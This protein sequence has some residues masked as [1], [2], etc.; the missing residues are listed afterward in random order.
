MSY[1]F[2]VVMSTETVSVLTSFAST[3]DL[4]VSRLTDN[5]LSSSNWTPSMLS[6]SNRA[7]TI[8]SNFPASTPYLTNKSQQSEQ[9]P[10][11]ES[12]KKSSTNNRGSVLYNTLVW[13][14]ESRDDALQ[15]MH[16]NID[17]DC[18]STPKQDEG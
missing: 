3:R 5:S 13:S 6:D 4:F 14:T 12:P 2:L 16:H 18:R 17:E 15:Q 10:S 8:S 11:L 7:N 9:Y 1:L